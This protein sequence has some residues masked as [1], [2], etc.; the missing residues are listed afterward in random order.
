MDR[1]TDGYADKQTDIRYL[2]NSNPY[3]MVYNVWVLLKEIQIT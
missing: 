2:F 3:R 1:Q